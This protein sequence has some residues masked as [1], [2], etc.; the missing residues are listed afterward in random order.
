M[1]EHIDTMTPPENPEYLRDFP[2]VRF[3]STKESFVWWW[4]MFMF[5]EDGVRKQIVAFWTTKTYPDVTINGVDWG[6]AD[7][8]TGTPENFS[9]NGM[10]TWWFWD[11]ERFHETT[12]H[13]SIFEN[14]VKDGS[15][16]IVSEDVHHIGNDN[17]FFLRFCRDPEDFDLR[18]ESVA[19]NPPPVG[20]KRTLLTKKMGFDAL[21]IYN[22]GFSGSLSIMGSKRSIEGS[23]YMQNITLNSPTVPWLWGVFHRD[24]GSYLTYFTSF[25]GPLMFRRKVEDR[26]WMDNK[27]K[28]M[29]KNLNYTPKGKETKRFENVRYHI[30]RD[31]RG[32][33]ETEAWGS[34]CEEKLKIKIRTL[35]KTTYAFE[36]KKYWKNKFFYNEFPSEIIELEYTDENGHVHKDD[37]SQWTGNSEYSWGVLLN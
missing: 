31:E 30:S 2:P 26:P 23:L 24:D 29:N 34:L 18:I 1:F 25:I 32:M 12:P 28:F 6:P 13:V 22:A 19:P 10:T 37:C 16:E 4:W 21:K 20:Y 3:F 35:G 33:P 9:Y 36:R 27:F 15:V 7:E 14:T 17:R 5:K 8:L 11:G